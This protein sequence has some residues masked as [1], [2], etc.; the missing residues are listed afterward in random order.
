MTSI[1]PYRIRVPLL[2]GGPHAADASPALEALGSRRR[3]RAIGSA[4][5]R[6]PRC[7]AA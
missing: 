5:R 7:A 3:S 2:L 1:P 6:R 4:S